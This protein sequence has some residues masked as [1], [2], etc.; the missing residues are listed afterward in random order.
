[1]ATLQLGCL[2]AIGATLAWMAAKETE[3]HAI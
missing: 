1:M 2:A 3:I